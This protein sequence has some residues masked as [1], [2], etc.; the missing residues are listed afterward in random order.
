MPHPAPGKENLVLETCW[1]PQAG[2]DSAHPHAGGCLLNSHIE[3]HREEI[4][5][6]KPSEGNQ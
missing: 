6:P 5:F 1:K 4:T 2:E 3:L